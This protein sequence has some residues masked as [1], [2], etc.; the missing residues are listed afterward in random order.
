VNFRGVTFT[1]AIFI[2]VTVSVY[3]GIVVTGTEKSDVIAVSVK[4]L[5]HFYH[6]KRFYMLTDIFVQRCTVLSLLKGKAQYS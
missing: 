4:A 2:D 5:V 1:A 3:A 6:I